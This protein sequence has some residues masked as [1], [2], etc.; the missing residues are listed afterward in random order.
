MDLPSRPVV[1]ALGLSG[2][3]VSIFVDLGWISRRRE[4]AHNASRVSSSLPRFF[5]LHCAF[6]AGRLNLFSSDRTLASRIIL[7]TP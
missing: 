3:V 1:K 7:R 5:F 2:F 6:C 4:R